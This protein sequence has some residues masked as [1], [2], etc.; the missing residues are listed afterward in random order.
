MEPGCFCT[1]VISDSKMVELGNVKISAS[2]V[3]SPTKM[4]LVV[5]A[6]DCNEVTVPISEE[7]VVISVI[8]PEPVS[9]IT[10]VNS[11]GL[12]GAPAVEYEIS[13]DSVPE[14]IGKL[15]T[16]K[17]GGGGVVTTVNSPM[18]SSPVVV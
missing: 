9:S 17:G 14:P 8:S 6:R 2:V 12:F 5:L 4:S 7:K 10:V 11:N 13:P 16:G 3:C 1:V 18:S 15:V